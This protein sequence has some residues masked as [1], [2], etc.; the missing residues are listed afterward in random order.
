M[1]LSV[2]FLQWKVQLGPFDASYQ[3]ENSETPLPEH[4]SPEED[5]DGSGVEEDDISEDSDI[6]DEN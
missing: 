2:N 6:V 4:Q 3:K 5:N 1:E